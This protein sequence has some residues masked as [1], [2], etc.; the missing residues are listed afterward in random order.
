MLLSGRKESRAL[1]GILSPHTICCPCGT[2]QGDGL[3]ARRE[4][5]P[6][7]GSP[8]TPD[9]S[10]LA[11]R[12]CKHF[13]S[14]PESSHSSAVIDPLP[15]GGLHTWPKRLPS[16]LVPVGNAMPSRCTVGR[17]FLTYSVGST[18]HSISLTSPV[19]EEDTGSQCSDL[20]R[21]WRSVDLQGA[22]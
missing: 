6:L 16:A 14:G 19:P 22:S 5:Q 18:K 12:L 11:P 15:R 3:R 20:H 17:C 13:L 10:A 9:V 1:M 2:I 21:A 4:A 7:A 8:S